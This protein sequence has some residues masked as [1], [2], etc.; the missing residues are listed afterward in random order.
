M[1]RTSP[2]RYCWGRSLAQRSPLP[3]MVKHLQGHL[4]SLCPATSHG[5]CA[6]CCA[7]GQGVFSNAPRNPPGLWK[8]PLASAFLSLTAVC[9]SMRSPYIVLLLFGDTLPVLHRLT[10][11]ASSALG[12]VAVPGCPCFP[13]EEVEASS[14]NPDPASPLPQASAES[15]IHVRESDH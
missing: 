8:C 10:T 11:D 7:H 13:S 4:P 9:H 12:A 14:I 2:N 3:H 1:T 5:R 6:C 15:C